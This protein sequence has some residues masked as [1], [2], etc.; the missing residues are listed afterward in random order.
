[1]QINT[2]QVYDKNTKRVPGLWLE[3]TLA[4]DREVGVSRLIYFSAKCYLYIDL[5]FDL[6]KNSIGLFICS[7]I[8]NNNCATFI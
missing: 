6:V 7:T 5:K 3:F 4:N 2:H 8:Q 1:M